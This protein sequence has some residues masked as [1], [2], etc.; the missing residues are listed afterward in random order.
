MLILVR[1]LYI[2]IEECTNE[3]CHQN[4]K[5]ISDASF[6]GASNI[7]NGRKTDRKMKLMLLFQISFRSDSRC[8]KIT[9]NVTFEFFNFSIMAFSAIFCPIKMTCLVTLFDEKLPRNVA[10]EFFHHFLSFEIDL[11]G[12]TV[13][14][15][16]FPKNR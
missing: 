15:S 11:S 1:P 7:R 8:L 10:F 3:T 4:D 12:N 16:R 14:L 6:S 5:T 9:Q 13:H 2:H